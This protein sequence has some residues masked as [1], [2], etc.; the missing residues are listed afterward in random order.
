MTI[1]RR[2]F[3]GMAGA[4]ATLPWWGMGRVLAA[5]PGGTLTIGLS[6]EPTAIDPHWHL[7]S[8]NN[9]LAQHIFDRV[10][11]GKPDMTVGPGL[12]ERWKALD[13][14]TWEFTLRDGV[15]FHNGD[16]LTIEDIAFTLERAQNVPG[17]IFNMRSYLQDKVLEKVSDRV[18]LIRTPIPNPVVADELSTCAIVSKAAAG[19]ATTDDYNSGK[20]AIG[21][22]PYKL[23]EADLTSRIVLARNEDYWGE[24]PSFTQVVIRPIP[25][26]GSRIAA[27]RARDVDLIDKVPPADVK[28]LEALSDVALARG[29]PNRCIFLTMDQSRA[30]SPF[31]R[32]KD[33]GEIPNVLRDHRVREAMN[34]AI[35]RKAIC[36]RILGGNGIPARQLVPDTIFGA[37]PDLVLPAVDLD[38]AKA[39]L[40]EA[41]LPDGF[42]LTLHGPNDRFIRD[43]EVTQA[44]AQMLSR[45]G[46]AVQV[47]T[48]PASVFY[49]RATSGGPEGG[50]TYSF[51]LVGYGASMGDSGP[52]LRNVLMTQDK[53]K[54]HGANNRLRYSNPEV[55]ALVLEGQSTMD[56]AKRAALYGRASKM[57]MDDVAIIPLYH[58]VDV[59]AFK[60]GLTYAGRN[61]ERTLAMDVGI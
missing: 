8:Q 2:G 49:Q 10:A 7:V 21:T 56:D 12:A 19:T 18:F 13:E 50:S 11:H 43:S 1:A 27:L 58:P 25:V 5:E 29:T 14:L 41:G 16:P 54:G 40:A 15:R 55:D 53:E 52:S 60:S 20:A 38:R 34:L 44:V 57:A 31:V 28:G 42:S 45:I 23:V 22:G 37:S 33:G 26:G 32:G 36:D 39:L 35:D 47:D 61:D 3:L 46:I 30:V 6:T 17:A 9:A 24:K 48:M 4:A 51:F 59:W